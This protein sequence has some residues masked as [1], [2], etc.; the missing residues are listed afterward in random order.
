VNALASAGIIGG[1]NGLFHP[2]DTLTLGQLVTLLTRF[3]DAKET[4]MPDDI[5]YQAHW[6]YSN[7]VTA[8]AYGW[9]DDV[10]EFD[11]DRPVTRGEAI[12]FINSIFSNS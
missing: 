10:S 8:A 12:E 1:Y 11:P 9:I 4:I 5:A 7:I 3:V 2:A 6:A